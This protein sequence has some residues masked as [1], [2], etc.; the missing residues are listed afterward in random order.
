MIYTTRPFNPSSPYPNQVETELNK[1]NDN[2]QILSQI[3]LDNNPTS[4]VLKSDVFTF[5]RV[6]LTD[7]ISDYML[8]VGEEAIINFT[9]AASVP[10]NI[11]TQSETYYEVHL[12]CSNAGGSSGAN[13]S[14]VF[15]NPNNTTY[16]N[17]FTEVLYFR[18]TSSSGNGS[19]THSAFRCGLGF[20][21]GTYYITNFTQ[22]KNV[23]GFYNVYG[24]ATGNP[25]V[26]IFSSDWR[27]TTLAWT[28][29]G[30][31]TFPQSTSG[32]IIVKRLV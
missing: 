30:T 17:A 20:T 2:F 11:A 23:R 18:H 28:S 6:N 22:Y 1:A 15:L 27:N 32:Y 26:V 24:I 14:G 8:Q 7:A 12:I 31:F 16:T 25:Y 13:A 3:F 29:L 5:R 9:N 21:N 19:N 4:G 10:L